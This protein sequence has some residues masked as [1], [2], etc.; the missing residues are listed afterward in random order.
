G[1]LRFL[2]L[3]LEVGVSASEQ[4]GKFLLETGIDLVEGLLEARPRLAIDLAHRRLERLQRV[5]QVLTLTVEVFLALGLLLELAD[6]R[7]IDLPQALDFS[8]GLLQIGL[9]GLRGRLGRERSEERGQI[10]RSG[11]ELLGDALAPYAHLLGGETCIV[12]CGTRRLDALV[13]GSLL[14]LALAQ[15]GIEILAC[16]AGCMQF[17]LDL[18][19]RLERALELGCK[20]R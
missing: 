6:G 14:A 19:A 9:P 13:E 10:D 12:Q 16:D 5:G 1:I 11:R 4:A 20:R 8:L 15:Q 7:K 17:A 3:D 18:R 2:P